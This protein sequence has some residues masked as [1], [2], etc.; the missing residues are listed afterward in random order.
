MTEL[1]IE[2][3]RMDLGPDTIIARTFQQ[4]LLS[5][6]GSVDSPYTNSFSLPYTKNNARVLGNPE[7]PTSLTD[8]PYIKLD[9]V[10]RQHGIEQFPS[11][12]AEVQG[13]E[14][15][16]YNVQVFA[17]AVPFFDLLGEKTLQELDLSEYNHLWDFAN[18]AAGGVEGVYSYD[19]IDRGKPLDLSKVHPSF[20][21]PSVFAK[22][23][24]E[25]IFLEAGVG[26]IM[27][28]HEDLNRLVLPFCNE[29]PVHN[30]AWIEAHTAT[31]PVTSNDRNGE[32]YT[33][34]EV[35]VT[36]YGT[37][38]VSMQVELTSFNK[39]V[40]AFFQ[41][42]KNGRILPFTSKSSTF[43]NFGVHTFEVAYEIEPGMDL[44]G[45]VV[46]TH[47]PSSSD[48]TFTYQDY[49]FTV[50]YDQE[51]YY[52]T[53]WDISLNLPDLKQKEFVLAL[54]KL[55]G[56]SL[57]YEPYEGSIH[58]K[59]LADVLVNMPQAK[60]WSGKVDYSARP[61]LAYRLPET[62]INNLYTWAEDETVPAGLGD[63]VLVASNE[64]L[65]KERKAVELPF[66]ASEVV[67]GL[68]K[69]GLFSRNN[70]V[71]EKPYTMTVANMAAREAIPEIGDIE[72]VLVEDA[73]DD[74]TV[75]SGS[76][77]YTFYRQVDSSQPDQWVKEEQEEYD[78]NGIE[79]R[80]ALL[81]DTTTTFTLKQG[82]S[83]QT[84]TRRMVDFSGL[85]FAVLLP[86]YHEVP[87]R[88]L[89]R[90]QLLRVNVL[91]TAQDFA[92]LDS[93][94]PVWVEQFQDFYYLNK[95]TD[96]TSEA[97]PCEAELIKLN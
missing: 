64:H 55:F 59:P 78:T 16:A 52:G 92:E 44:T 7:E 17:G 63:G 72:T 80:L 56:W 83:T 87:Q 53:E 28:A 27:A 66:A 68:L 51:A 2:G 71:L 97:V 54:C 67:N 35:P 46:N 42:K 15:N 85:H 41:L 69:I 6:Q 11:S 61:K 25:R 45:L 94:V 60:D 24:W 95:I 12:I 84:V 76:A 18:V 43:S 37:L 77:I 10:I 93:T 23:I 21:Y 8:T 32:T 73:S 33:E 65:E 96:Y 62:A 34:K 50:S 36:E 89:S 20:L 5:S 29:K 75:P 38:K 9:T 4:N 22:A 49:T 14:D 70:P 82:N 86:K 57:V 39:P 13:F 74:P 58:V 48:T 26:V 91:L 19:L 81:A 79:P 30:Q 31:Y 90:V 47:L 40:Q 1:Y 88:V 3:Q